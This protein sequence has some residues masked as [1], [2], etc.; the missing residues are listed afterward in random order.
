MS[1]THAHTT[2]HAAHTHGLAAP[3]GGTPALA[4]VLAEYESV[5]AILEAAAKVRDAGYTRWESFTPC[6][7]HGLD[8]AMGHKA[9]RLPWLVLACGLTGMLTGIFLVWWTNAI[10]PD[11]PYALRGYPFIISGKP[12]FSFPAN[13]PPIFELTILFSAFGSFFGMLAMNRLPRFNHPVF[14]SRRF[15]RAMQDRFFIA[16]EAS[17]PNFDHR[18]TTQLLRDTGAAA[19]EDLEETP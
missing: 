8:A 3:T 12:M 10:S 19:V 9:S 4:G 6:P 2:T 7:I 18:R 14:S 1:N 13:I 15:D 5:D 16:I 11:V 17:D